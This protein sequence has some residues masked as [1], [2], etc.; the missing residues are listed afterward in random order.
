MFSISKLAT[1]G[2]LALTFAVAACDNAVAPTERNAP[3]A[4]LMQEDVVFDVVCEVVDPLTGQ[5]GVVGI[6]DPRLEQIE[7]SFCRI[8]QQLGLSQG[9]INSLGAKLFAAQ[10]ALERGN[11][12]AA[13][14]ILLALANE[15][16]AIAYRT[17]C[18]PLDVRPECAQVNQEI[19][20]LEQ[21]IRGL[22]L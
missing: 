22:L 6:T 8:V 17:V 13:V 7:N 11:V 9:E 16:E 15:L 3:G 21:L 10:A 2:A 12:N 19:T 18:N 4:A 1:A 14:N 20:T 5:Q